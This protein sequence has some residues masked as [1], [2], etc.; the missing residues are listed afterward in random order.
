MDHMPIR[1]R[2]SCIGAC[3]RMNNDAIT[4]RNPLALKPEGRATTREN[5][6]RRLFNR[7]KQDVITEVS[8]PFHL[9]LDELVRKITSIADCNQCK[10]RSG[11]N[12]HLNPCVH[13][14]AIAATMNKKPTPSAAIPFVVS[15]GSQNSE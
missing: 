5:A 8:I 4:S 9:E 3:S 1:S 6:P 10:E 7:G 11:A 15:F 14:A 2:R 13:L 12:Y